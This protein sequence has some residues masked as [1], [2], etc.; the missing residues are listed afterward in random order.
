[1]NNRKHKKYTIRSS[2]TKTGSEREK[3]FQQ[4]EEEK[5]E[6]DESGCTWSHPMKKRRRTRA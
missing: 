6:E 2:K 4:E 1:V 5:K 3:M